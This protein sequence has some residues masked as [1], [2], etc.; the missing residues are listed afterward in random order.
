MRLI[1][2]KMNTLLIILIAVLLINAC[3]DDNTNEP[4]E[5]T[6]T[7]TYKIGVLIPITGAGQ[8]N[9][10]QSQKTIEF[11]VT[12]INNYFSARN[13]PVRI[14]AIIK[15]S[16]TDSTQALAMLKEFAEDTIKIVVGPYSSTT[17]TGLKHFADS[18]GILLI[19]HSAVS[20]TL[21]IKGDNIFRFVPDDSWQAKA[22]SKMM[23]KDGKLV[24]IPLVRDDV[25]GRALYSNVEKELEQSQLTLQIPIY[26]PPTQTNFSAIVQSIRSK[27]DDLEATFLKSEI[28]VYMITYDEGTII[29]KQV[30]YFDDMKDVKFYGSSAFAWNNTLQ[31]DTA[32]AATA[33]A[34]E[35]ECPIYGFNE[36][37]S[38]RYTPLLE[39]LSTKLIREPDS[40]ALSIYDAAFVA[41]ITLSNVTDTVSIE[42]IKAEVRNVVAIYEGINGPID[43]DENDDR[44]NVIYDFMSLKYSENLYKWH[45]T[46]IYDTKKDEITRK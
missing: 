38:N 21:A 34:T 5:P 41:G 18:A 40:Y 1:M 13:I 14:Q 17:L 30:S 45:S 32:A 23:L 39:R 35:L 26:Y 10:Q 4:P 25:W 42:D 22:I 46:A 2:K 43:L 9:G 11:A 3:S 29:M 36:N 28:G 24:V 15:D 7:T 20:S 8:L 31:K 33:V 16:G 44:F 19:S 37:Y 27:I 6:P 12:D